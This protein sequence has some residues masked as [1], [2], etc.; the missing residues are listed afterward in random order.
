MRTALGWG[1]LCW[2]VSATS[3]GPNWPGFRGPT[4]DG[5]SDA[6][7]A[8]LHWSETEHVLWKTPIPGHGWSS[9]VVWGQQVWVTTGTPDGKELFALCLDL[10][11]GRVV[12]TVKVFDVEQPHPKIMAESSYAS[13]TPVI[14]E[15]R[16]YVHF[17]TYGTACL[18]TSDGA[19]IWERRDLTLDHKEGA[20]ASPAL[21]GD[22]LILP[23]DGQDVQY[24]IALDKKNGK[25]VWKTERS[26]DF[27]DTVPYQRK[28]YATPLVADLAGKPQ[29]IS[30]GAR[31]AYSYDPSSGKELWKVRYKGWSNVSGPVCGHGL[32][33]LNGGFGGLELLAVRPDSAGDVTDS[34]VAWKLSRNV[35]KLSSPVLV[36]DHL[37]LCSDKGVAGCIEARTGKVLWQERLGGNQSASPVFAAGRVYFA[38]EDGRTTVLRAGT[39]FEVLAV[40]PLKGMMKASPAVVGKALILR[41]E[42]QLY[43]IE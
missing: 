39:I 23:C 11:T 10:A 29:L 30:V 4:G 42:T 25:T 6:S 15:A 34:Q 8:P 1:L 24:L 33:F 28:A 19:T 22:L 9:P 21:W 35:P 13:P 2:W 40:N 37:F 31:A 38:G 18:S 7:Q 17:G 32:V 36:G 3:G 20:G 12:R 43:R 26:A 16:I 14:E 41:T 5:R 27:R